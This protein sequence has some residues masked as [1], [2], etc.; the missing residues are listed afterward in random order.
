MEVIDV[1]PTQQQFCWNSH[2]SREEAGLGGVVINRPKV[3]SF[4]LILRG[5]NVKGLGSSIISGPTIRF[6][7]NGPHETTAATEIRV[8]E[9]FPR[10]CQS[11]IWHKMTT[12]VWLRMS[13]AHCSWHLAAWRFLTLRF[14]WRLIAWRGGGKAYLDKYKLGRLHVTL[15]SICLGH[16]GW[17][18]TFQ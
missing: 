2:E 8:F 18:L 13:M 7:F 14:G 3:S 11:E 16:P 9:V 1:Q 6:L 17:L 15:F 10:G 12:S 5:Q 4:L